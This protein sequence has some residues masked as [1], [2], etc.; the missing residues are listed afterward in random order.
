[1]TDIYVKYWARRHEGKFSPE[2]RLVLLVAPA[3][4]VPAG[5]LMFGF[6]AQRKLHWAVIYIGYGGINYVTSVASITFTLVMDSY[7]E[8]AAEALLMI[9][10]GSKIIAWAFTYGFVPWTTSAGYERVS[11]PYSPATSLLIFCIGFRNH[12]RPLCRLDLG[13]Y[14]IVRIRS[15]YPRVHHDEDEGGLLVGVAR[16][17]KS[18]VSERGQ[19]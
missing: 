9:N 15:T 6:G 3:L 18:L 7:F 14:T 1:M 4:I 19:G 17:S 13:S 11:A 5:L 10:G 8:V 12:G 16:V 2:A